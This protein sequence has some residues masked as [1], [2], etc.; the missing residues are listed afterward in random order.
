MYAHGN[1]HEQEELRAVFSCW[2]FLQELPF[3]VLHVCLC[4][5]CNATPADTRKADAGKH[6]KSLGTQRATSDV[7]SIKRRPVAPSLSPFSRILPSRLLGRRC[8]GLVGS[9]LLP[10]GGAKPVPCQAGLL[11]KTWRCLL[12]G[13]IT[14]HC[15][16]TM[17]PQHRGSLSPRL[18][19]SRS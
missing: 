7:Q 14:D 2:C 10:A 9:F 6:W 4:H 5:G 19:H 17:G 12:C 16:V 15:E 11:L 1:C 18:R 8:C 3:A 13:D